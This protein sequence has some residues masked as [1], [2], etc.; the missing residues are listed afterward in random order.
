MNKRLGGWQC[1]VDLYDSYVIKT[2][3]SRKEIKQEVEKFLRWKNK[4]EELEER[5]DKMISDIKNST[6]VIKKSKIPRKL[7]ANLEFIENGRVKQKK[8]LPLDQA[9]NNLNEKER[10]KLIDKI[11]KFLLKLWSYGIHEKTFKLFSNLGIDDKEIVLIDVFEITSN[12]EKVLKQIKKKSWAK[13]ENY[14]KH[15]SNKEINYLINKLDKTFT[16][17]NLNKYW[18]TR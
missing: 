5:T 3:K 18:K 9:L 14:K 10:F 6:K 11:M 16:K 13:I 2:P 7:L 8:V 15:L 12:K 17:K 4:L 1:W